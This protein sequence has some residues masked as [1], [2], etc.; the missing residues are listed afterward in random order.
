MRES[1]RTSTA[2]GVVK[3]NDILLCTSLSINVSFRYHLLSFSW[4]WNKPVKHRIFIILMQSENIWYEGI[5]CKNNL[6]SFYAKRNDSLNFKFFD[7][8][9]QKLTE[10]SE[11]LIQS[12]KLHPKLKS[13]KRFKT[14]LRNVWIFFITFKFQDFTG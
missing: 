8:C 12:E 14:Q 13:W 1:T 4:R 6:I 2:V 9:Q 10:N 3:Q 11:R 5:Y 7:A